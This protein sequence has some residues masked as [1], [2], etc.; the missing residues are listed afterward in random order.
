VVVRAVDVHK[1]YGRREALK[2]VSL[3]IHRAETV[4]LIGPPGSG[5]S[6]LLRCLGGLD[7]IDSGRI[8]VNGRI[9][10]F[11]RPA[12]ELGAIELLADVGITMIVVTDELSF[13]KAAADRVLMLDDGRVIEE[14]PPEHFFLDPHEEK[15]KLFLSKIADGA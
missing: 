12:V 5:K 7:E 9:A 13:V 1:R 3:E 6:S 11:D 10:L 2:G 15:T 8:E 4:C 14:G